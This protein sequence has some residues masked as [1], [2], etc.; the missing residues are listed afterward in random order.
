[1]NQDKAL[2]LAAITRKMIYNAHDRI[3]IL[4]KQ[5]AILNKKLDLIIS[6]KGEEDEPEND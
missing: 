3:D 6:P 4:A 2:E 5:I 1:M